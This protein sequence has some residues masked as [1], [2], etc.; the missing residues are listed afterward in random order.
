[1]AARRVLAATAA[2]IAAAV[3]LIGPT[4]A[5]A[6]ED[7]LAVHLSMPNDVQAGGPAIVM[8]MSIENKTDQ[9]IRP[10]RIFVFELDG[11]KASQLKFAHQTDGK[12][13]LLTIRSQGG[14][15]RV[16]D[17]SRLEIPPRTTVD[18]QYGMQLLSGAPGGELKVT[19][20]ANASHDNLNPDSDTETANVAGGVFQGGDPTPSATASPT[21]ITP[22]VID[23]PFDSAAAGPPV[24]TASG[25][26]SGSG[27]P[28]FMYAIGI[29]LVLGGAGLFAFLWF[30]RGPEQAEYYEEE[31]DPTM[32]RRAPPRVY[33]G[34]AAHPYPPP[35]ERAP[36][37][38]TQ[39][40]PALGR[41][42]RQLP[43]RRD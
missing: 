24:D 35:Q 19:A 10:S 7:G 4:P 37:P 13:A 16:V 6:D 34:T 41:P 28:W 26:S 3:V 30:N 1:M 39:Q 8:T 33:G 31:V 36:T 17:S 12:W 42:T 23:T 5:M 14:N 27:L 21:E 32:I 40:M 9:G 22:S 38:P 2:L 18:L 25:D 11:L 15:L 29:I 20:T 43:T